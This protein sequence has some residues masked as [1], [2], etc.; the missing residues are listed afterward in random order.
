[1]HKKVQDDMNKLDICG[2]IIANDN[3]SVISA[4]RLSTGVIR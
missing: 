2:R 1:M 3:S 4:E